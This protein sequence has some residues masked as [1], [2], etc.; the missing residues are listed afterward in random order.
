MPA[1]FEHPVVVDGSAIDRFG[2]ANNLVYLRWLMQAAEA[3]SA[4]QGWP[5]AAY[6]RL[7]AGWFVRKHEIE[8]LRPALAGDALVVRTWV[9]TL[10]K[11]T[12]L[13]RYEI[14]RRPGGEKLAVASTHWVFVDFA[15]QA[16]RR[17]PPEVGGCFE[18]VPD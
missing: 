12:S 2:H 14:L 15:K 5:L 11:V 3:H 6:E 4:A 16:A 13:R 8:Y 1:I 18:V 10:E 17:I 9:A 7:G